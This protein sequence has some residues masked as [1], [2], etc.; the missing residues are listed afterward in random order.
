MGESCI[1][2]RRFRWEQCN[3]KVLTA[4]IVFVVPPP[5]VLSNSF[6]YWPT[7]PQISICLLNSIPSDSLIVMFQGN[8]SLIWHSLPHVNS[9]YCELD[10]F[11]PKNHEESLT[12][13]TVPHIL[14]IM[15]GLETKKRAIQV[16]I[17]CAQTRHYTCR[18]AYTV[19]FLN[20]HVLLRLTYCF[21]CLESKRLI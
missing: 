12:E 17:T 8:E 21:L 16:S 14:S 10:S 7:V 5:P 2:F 19:D 18:E 20:P 13:G 15:T 3:W 9:G 11:Q 1:C 4:L 6:W